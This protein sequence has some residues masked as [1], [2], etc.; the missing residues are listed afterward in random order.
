MTD[1]YL[2]VVGVIVLQILDT[3]TAEAAACLHARLKPAFVRSIV[4]DL[5]SEVQNTFCNVSSPTTIRPEDTGVQYFV[6]PGHI[7][8]HLV[9]K[10]GDGW[11]LVQHVGSYS[12]NSDA[13]PAV[14]HLWI[15]AIC[16]G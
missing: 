2:L 7:P 16:V 6:L 10:Q 5:P 11:R 1:R 15:R 9:G 14:L 12:H 8:K 13:L 4:D 3:H